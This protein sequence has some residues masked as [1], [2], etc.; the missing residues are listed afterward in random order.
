MV[1]GPFRFSEYPCKTCVPGVG[2]WPVEFPS[3]LHGDLEAPYEPAGGTPRTARGTPRPAPASFPTAHVVGVGDTE[4]HA[5]FPHPEW[6]TLRVAIRISVHERQQ[7]L[8]DLSSSCTL[9]VSAHQR[10]GRPSGA[11]RSRVRVAPGPLRNA[12]P[13]CT[14]VRAEASAWPG[15]RVTR[16]SRR[17]R[18]IP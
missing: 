18:S 8:K 7:A 13:A 4:T 14:S 11:K 5:S 10:R 6:V 9:L 16:G 3:W 15:R 2:R 1:N 12:F 17:R